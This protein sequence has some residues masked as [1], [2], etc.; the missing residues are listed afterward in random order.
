[1]SA[2]SGIKIHV[3]KLICTL[4]KG[5]LYLLFSYY[6][7]NYQ[8]WKRIYLER[9]LCDKAQIVFS[10]HYLLNHTVLTNYLPSICILLCSISYWIWFK[11][12]W[13]MCLGNTQ[14]S[15]HFNGQDVRKVWYTLRALKPI[16]RRH[17]RTT[18]TTMK[19]WQYFLIFL[20]SKAWM[21]RDL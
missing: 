9:K 1:M 8:E 13:K 19:W 20:Y 11:A 15:R 2:L 10:C 17:P 3:K 6:Q 18:I 4:Y 7:F 16:F 5:P 14:V 21:E 12:D